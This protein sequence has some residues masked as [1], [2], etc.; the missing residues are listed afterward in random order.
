MFREAPSCVDF[1]HEHDCAHLEDINVA[2]ALL[3]REPEVGHHYEDAKREMA[4]MASL[5]THYVI[6]GYLV[7]WG[8]AL[9]DRYS[10]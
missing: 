4:R 5:R 10:V 2:L 7:K 6:A 8:E 1:I 3:G 9:R